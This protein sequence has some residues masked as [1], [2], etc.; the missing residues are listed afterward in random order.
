MFRALR[1]DRWREF[2]TTHNRFPTLEELNAL[3]DSVWTEEAKY[4]R[5]SQLPFVGQFFGGTVTKLQP[6]GTARPAQPPPAGGAT[7]NRA[8]PAK[9]NEPPPPPPAGERV[10]RSHIY[11]KD[12]KQRVPVYTDGT[13]GIPEVVK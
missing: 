7:P 4:P 5:A 11:S 12:R 1:G 6:R 8:N 9:P 10:I 13:R 2:R 3:R